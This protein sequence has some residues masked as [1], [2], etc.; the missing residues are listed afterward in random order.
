MRRT[1]I[2]G[3]A[4][5]FLGSTGNLWAKE[6]KRSLAQQTIEVANHDMDQMVSQVLANPKSIQVIKHLNEQLPGGCLEFRQSKYSD[7]SISILSRSETSVYASIQ[8]SE[9]ADDKDNERVAP[10]QTICPEPKMSFDN[11]QL[12]LADSVRNLL[13]H[14]EIVTV[15]EKAAKLH[16]QPG[17][18][19]T[20]AGSL[21]A[22]RSSGIS[23]KF[24]IESAKLTTHFSVSTD[25]TG[26]TIISITEIQSE[27]K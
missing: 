2:V 6:S 24:I 26:R 22:S 23:T 19:K 13:Q 4:L 1:L 21:D 17:K 5:A 27:T 8:L 16:A 9:T 18:L 7:K 12:F 10:A 11:N 15:L 14:N 3:T 20:E 25:F